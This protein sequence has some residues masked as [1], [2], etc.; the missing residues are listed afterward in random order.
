MPRHWHESAARGATG[1]PLEATMDVVRAAY[2]EKV[3]QHPPDRDRKYLN[4]C[5]M[6]YATS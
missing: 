2:L 6:L 3:R 5:V 1:V 4:R